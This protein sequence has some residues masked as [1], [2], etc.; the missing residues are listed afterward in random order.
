MGVG[1]DPRGTPSMDIGHPTPRCAG[2][3]I[4]VLGRHR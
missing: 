3:L 4:P 2:Q 1:Q